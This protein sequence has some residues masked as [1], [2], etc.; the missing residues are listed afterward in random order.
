MTHAELISKAYEVAIKTEY[1]K[2]LSDTEI[3][4]K[5]NNMN[6]GF[7]IGFIKMNSKEA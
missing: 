5:L 6:D 1:V 2:G 7:L 4:N 3:I